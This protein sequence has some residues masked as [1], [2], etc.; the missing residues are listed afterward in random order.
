MAAVG[1]A[2][3]AASADRGSSSAIELV[4]IFVQVEVVILVGDDVEADPPRLLDDGP[5]LRAGTGEAADHHLVELADV[6]GVLADQERTGLVDQ[7]GDAGAPVRLA[8]PRDALDGVDPDQ[9]SLEVAL[10]DRRPHVGDLHAVFP[11][12]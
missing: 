11:F 2:A 1:A 4:V 6:E 7:L 9:D 5:D 10:H 3:A 12:P 8:Q